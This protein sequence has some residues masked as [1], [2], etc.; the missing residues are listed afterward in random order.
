MQQETEHKN[1]RTHSFFIALTTA[2]EN[3]AEAVVELII[4]LLTVAENIQVSIATPPLRRKGVLTS[5]APY[6][7]IYAANTRTHRR[8]H[9]TGPKALKASDMTR[10]AP[11]YLIRSEPCKSSSWAAN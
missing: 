9:V 1:D 5:L 3:G 2:L 4:A 7:G 6:L 8:P 10:R 11:H